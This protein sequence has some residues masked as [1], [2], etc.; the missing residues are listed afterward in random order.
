M[1][2]NNL[3]FSIFTIVAVFAMGT[4]AHTYQ[5]AAAQS[6]TLNCAP[7]CFD[8]VSDHVREAEERLEEADLQGAQAELATVKALINQLEKTTGGSGT[9]VSTEEE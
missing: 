3:V 4:A 1:N 7:N 6:A 2:K 5:S 9:G 8:E